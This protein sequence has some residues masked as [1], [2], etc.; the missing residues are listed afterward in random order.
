MNAISFIAEYQQRVAY[1]NA[2]KLMLPTVS[3]SC[4]CTDKPS[5]VKGPPKPNSGQFKIKGPRCSN[6]VGAKSKPCSLV[7]GHKGR[8]R[9]YPPNKSRRLPKKGVL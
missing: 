5:K 3:H 4:E 9:S 8:C 6:L 2:I 7:E 1:A